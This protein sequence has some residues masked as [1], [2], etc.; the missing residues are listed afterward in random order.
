[1]VGPFGGSARYGPAAADDDDDD[2]VVVV[3]VPGRSEGRTL[4]RSLSGVAGRGVQRPRL[5][6]RCEGRDGSLREG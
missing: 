1:M 4:S 6:G 3:V 5:S 2:G